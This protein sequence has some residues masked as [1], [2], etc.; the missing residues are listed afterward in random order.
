MLPRRDANKHLCANDTPD[1]SLS[2]G[3]SSGAAWRDE[4]RFHP[5]LHFR[6]TPPTPASPSVLV[7][8]TN[9]R[10]RDRPWG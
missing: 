4:E 5:K 10:D 8:G 7:P 1:Q 9:H 2:A 6:V 3:R